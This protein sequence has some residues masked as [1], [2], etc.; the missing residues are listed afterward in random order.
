MGRDHWGW[1]RKEDVPTQTPISQKISKDLK[2]KGMMF[3][4]PTIIYAYAGHWYGQRSPRY[5]L[6]V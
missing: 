6:E 1:S 5:L 2:S 3:V 4:G